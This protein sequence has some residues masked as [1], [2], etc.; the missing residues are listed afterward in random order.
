M[1]PRIALIPAAG[2][3][4]RMLPASRV[5][6]KALI[7]VIDRP[8]L[9]YV[10]EEAVHAG[11]ETVVVIV[12]PDAGQL[13]ESHFAA[14][15]P[16]PGL[17]DLDVHFE[18]QE[19]ALGLGDA[20][21]RGRRVIGEEPFYCLLADTIAP[22]GADYLGALRAGSD[23]RSVVALRTLTDMF[24]ERYG[25]I[26][27]GEWTAPSVIEV[28]G[29]VEKPGI[30]Q[31]PSRLGLIGRYLFTSEIFAMLKDAQ[32]GYGGEIQ[33]TDAIHELGA[34]GRCLGAVVEA[35]LLDV[36]NP[37]GLLEASVTLALG[38]DDYPSFGAFVRD[39]IEGSE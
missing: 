6:P 35:D 26:V 5:V 2:M 24:L 25:V 14:S 17:E 31:A 8:A 33:L 11:V 13:V 38:S 20:V 18:V 22:P 28:R 16:L 37:L 9:Q 34:G 15:E 30:E 39:A 12:S 3:G 36:G 23:G 1:N 19:E 10:V 7:T 21:L 32:P 4:T 27:P 29:A